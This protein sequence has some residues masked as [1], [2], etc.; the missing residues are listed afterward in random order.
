MTT[1]VVIASTYVLVAGGVGCGNMARDV[2]VEANLAPDAGARPERDASPSPR[3]PESNSRCERDGGCSS[4][5]CTPYECSLSCPIG[6]NRND[7]GGSIEYHTRSRRSQA[8]W[9]WESP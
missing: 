3:T 2:I 4:N 5:R 8:T 7:P 9:R 1:R 6:C